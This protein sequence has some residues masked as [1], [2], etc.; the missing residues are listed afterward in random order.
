MV[1]KESK[2]AERLMARLSKES[3]KYLK[4]WCNKGKERAEL[5]NTDGV[6]HKR[7][8]SIWHC[9]NKINY[10]EIIINN[11]GY[12]TFDM[13]LFYSFKRSFHYTCTVHLLIKK[14][15]IVTSCHLTN[16]VLLIL[17]RILSL[18]VRLC[19]IPKII[20]SKSE[21]LRQMRREAQQLAVSKV[22][23]T[24]ADRVCIQRSSTNPN[25]INIAFFIQAGCLQ[26]FSCDQ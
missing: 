11:R 19:H 8:F 1:C 26:V 17:L 6:Y 10:N 25:G 9:K 7:W 4:Q 12:R 14:H 15:C 21:L 5:L 18:F 24:H 16:D 3:N 23:P 20:R 22:G 13:M 2:R